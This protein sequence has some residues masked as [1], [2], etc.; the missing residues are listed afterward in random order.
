MNYDFKIT[1]EY[2]DFK[3]KYFNKFCVI[4]SV[5][6][7]LSS[8]MWFFK[9]IFQIG[10]NISSAFILRIIPLFTLFGFL[11]TYKYKP[12][13]SWKIC[14]LNVWTSIIGALYDNYLISKLGSTLTGDGWISYFVVFFM[15]S[16]VATSQWP[17]Y[18]SY[19]VFPALVLICS[20]QYTPGATHYIISI[21]RPIST[22]LII[23]FGLSICSLFIRMA[24]YRLFEN[25]ILLKDLSKIDTLSKVY[26]RQ[27]LED[28]LDKNDKLKNDATLFMIDIDEF[29][30]INDNFGHIAGDEAIKF[31]ADIL[32][33]IIR[34]SDYIIRFGGDEFLVIFE[35]FVDENYFYDRIKE[36]LKRE[37][38]KYRITFSIGS[39]RCSSKELTFQ[40][41]IKMADA[42]LYESKDGGRDRITSF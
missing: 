40:A 39:F 10:A 41:A 5:I 9:D 1:E 30:K 34:K 7:S 17:I 20:E 36:Q 32:K 35:N 6:T 4:I 14:L 8:I 3:A 15:I 27:K 23:A 25:E 28:L 22:G 29:K 42:A 31:T 24:I 37:E 21:N 19:F 33:K 11:Y 12:R 16:I 13:D 2:K 38:N 26:N 18:L